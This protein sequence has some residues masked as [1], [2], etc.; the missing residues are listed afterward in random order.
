MPL[1]MFLVFRICRAPSSPCRAPSRSH[2]LEWRCFFSSW[3]S[4]RHSLFLCYVPRGESVSHCSAM[5]THILHTR[6]RLIFLMFRKTNPC[7][8]CVLR[9]RSLYNLCFF[10]ILLCPRG[11]VSFLGPDSIPLAQLIL[12]RDRPSLQ[13]L[14]PTLTVNIHRC[15]W[16]SL[17]NDLTDGKFLL[18]KSL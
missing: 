15:R 3:F 6:D 5:R 10:L 14:L 8:S 17:D 11:H 7:V 18:V 16:K 1:F 4:A 13:D 12:S 2:S 9:F